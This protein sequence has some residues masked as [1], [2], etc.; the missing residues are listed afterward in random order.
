MW[1]KQTL[2]TL[3]AVAALCLC[4]AAHAAEPVETL[5]TEL[6]KLYGD[7]LE[8]KDGIGLPCTVTRITPKGLLEFRTAWT[9]GT[10]TARLDGLA[11]VKMRAAAW[12]AKDPSCVLLTNGD[13]VTGKLVNLTDKEIVLQSAMLGNVRVPRSFAKLFI[14]AEGAANPLVRNFAR[15]DL[16]G[17]NVD[18]GRWVVH[19]GFL[20]CKG[21]GGISVPLP[22]MAAITIEVE[23]EAKHVRVALAQL[24]MNIQEGKP[25]RNGGETPY[26]EASMGTNHTSLRYRSG[27][28]SG[29]SS[30]RSGRSLMMEN[31]VYRITC[32]PRA[33]DMRLWA[34]DRQLL[35][36]RGQGLEHW[37]RFALT[38]TT[39]LAIKRI[40]IR[41]GVHPPGG[42]PEEKDDDPDAVDTRV[43]LQNGDAITPEAIAFADGVFVLTVLGTE[44]KCPAER[45]K[46]LDLVSEKQARPRRRKGE[47]RVR[48]GG[49][50]L[51]LRIRELTAETL[52]GDS[53]Y[54][55]EVRIPRKALRGMQFGVYDSGLGGR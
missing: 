2:R 41:P 46:R 32:D 29:G 47:A 28:G 16:Y 51:T 6:A 22:K 20:H 44:M 31:T 14:A 39:G 13:V 53:E 19:G 5:T 9:D 1:N 4:G 45:I 52:I 34:G 37:S 55:G 3:A 54:L 36:S 35:S 15:A 7:T 17:W 10:A 24:V 8:L 42:D 23:V 40:R 49:A 50:F 33:G 43:I 30:S 11:G 25:K 48:A 26:V 27:T 38:C 12:K 21:S 18:S